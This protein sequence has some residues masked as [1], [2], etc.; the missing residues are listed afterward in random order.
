M[1][2]MGYRYLKYK[3][4][5]KFENMVLKTNDHLMVCIIYLSNRFQNKYFNLKYCLH[6]QYNEFV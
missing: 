5:N 3:S 1:T 4:S 6:I 2:L